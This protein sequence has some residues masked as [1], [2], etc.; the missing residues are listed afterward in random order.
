MCWPARCPPETLRV[1]RIKVESVCSASGPDHLEVATRG[2][3]LFRFEHL[4]NPVEKIS[5]LFMHDAFVG[6]LELALSMF[7]QIPSN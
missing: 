2:P 5:L 7:L 3:D 6:K 4:R 1:I